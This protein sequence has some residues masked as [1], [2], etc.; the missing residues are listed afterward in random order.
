MV[1]PP[2][3]YPSYAPVVSYGSDPHIIHL[4]AHA[5]SQGAQEL[6]LPLGVMN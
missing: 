5:A 2:V 1:Y 3:V 4:H 6:Q